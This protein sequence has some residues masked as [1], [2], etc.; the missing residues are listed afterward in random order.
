MRSISL[1]V[2]LLLLVSLAYSARA[3]PV[4]SVSEPAPYLTLAKAIVD[5]RFEHRKKIGCC[6]KSRSDPP[7][8]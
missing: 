1:I 4:N 8:T 3:A 6:Q 7:L 5:Q 2:E